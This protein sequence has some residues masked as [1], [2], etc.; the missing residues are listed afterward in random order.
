[1]TPEEVAREQI[2]A[3]LKASG[4][5]VQDCRLPPKRNGQFIGVEGGR[6]LYA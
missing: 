6:A 3:A 4:W 2:D 5:L 1:M